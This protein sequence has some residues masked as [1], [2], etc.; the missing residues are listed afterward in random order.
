MRA[1][2][3]A[4]LLLLAAAFAG[5][6]GARVATVPAASATGQ[7]VVPNIGG[8]RL[9]AAKQALKKQR[10]KVG[11]IRYVYSNRVK[12]RHVLSQ[13]PRPGAHRKRGTRVNLVVSKGPRPLPAHVLMKLNADSPEGTLGAFGSVWV[14]NHRAGHVSRLDSQTGRTIAKIPAGTEVGWPVAGPDAVWA[15]GDGDGTITRIDPKTNRGSTFQSPFDGLCGLPAATAG[16]IWVDVCGGFGFNATLDRIDAVTHRVTATVAVGN[17]VDSMVAIGNTIWAASYN[18]AEILQFDAAT[19]TVMKRIGVSGCPLLTPT[20]YSSGYLWV[21][22][23]DGDDTE[24]C[25]GKPNVLRINVSTGAVAVVPLGGPAWIAT[26]DGY[27][28]ASVPD[29]SN[30]HQRVT[31]I[32]P[33]TLA[34][35]TWTR[36]PM[37]E[38]PDGFAFINHAL[39]IGWF[40]NS[41]IWVVKTQ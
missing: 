34:S 22:Q 15:V 35:T 6:V 32:D 13:R 9:S 20:S 12:T 18:P 40:T 39:W 2:R 29:Q 3:L 21:G 16:A 38:Q 11:S 19:G 14:S 23:K 17:G 28:W 4:G 30:H 5:S 25:T 41:S 27:A 36:L 31:R 33:N 10:C 8:K 26:G 7:C 1:L 24:P 37:D